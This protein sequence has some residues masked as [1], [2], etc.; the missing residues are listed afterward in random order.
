MKA[1]DYLILIVS[2]LL[3]ANVLL[4][5]SDDDGMNSFTG[6]A[7][8]QYKNRKMQGSELFLNRSMMVLTAFF[9]G[10]IFWSNSID[11]LF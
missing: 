2:F 11:R 3:I 8:E 1:A 6:V 5:Q 7:S 10:F 9:I 4:L